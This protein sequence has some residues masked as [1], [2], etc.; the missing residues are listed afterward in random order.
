MTPWIK[1][2]IG[3][4]NPGVSYVDTRHNIGF[5]FVDHLASNSASTWKNEKRFNAEISNCVVSG[6]RITLV[7]PLTYMNDSGQSFAKLLRYYRWE[8]QSVLVA[9]DEI[10]LP[11]G[12]KKLSDRGGPGGH[13]GMASIINNGGSNV[14][15]LRLGIGQKNNPN[16]SLSDHVLGA[17]SAEDLQVLQ[18]NTKQWSHSVELVVDK[19]PTQA[20]NFINRKSN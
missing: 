2:I 3:L 7:K 13:N 5:K 6:H 10:N 1:S 12:E 15:R 14:L 11:L 19:G 20:M 18:D 4:G 9:F 17:F 8:P 16:I